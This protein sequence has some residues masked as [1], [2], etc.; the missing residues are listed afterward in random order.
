M[1]LKDKHATY[2]VSLEYVLLF[3]CNYSFLQDVGK[4]PVDTEPNQNRQAL[5][6]V[7]Q[8]WAAHTRCSLLSGYTINQ[9][10]CSAHQPPVQHLGS[11]D[12]HTKGRH[13][14]YLLSI[15][16]HRD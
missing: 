4:C 14:N 11:F 3:T 5:I 15:L 9:N 7:K 2:F 6:K 12:D 8:G 13:L 1:E 10:E 16:A